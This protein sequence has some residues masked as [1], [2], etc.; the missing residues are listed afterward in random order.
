[1]RRHAKFTNHVTQ[2]IQIQPN[3]VP[4]GANTNFINNSMSQDLINEYNYRQNN[5][6]NNNDYIYEQLKVPLIVSILFFIFNLNTINDNLNAVFPSL[7]KSD[8]TL[9]NSGFALKSLLFGVAYYSLNNLLL[10]FSKM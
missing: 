8:S 3:Y 5:I 7:F 9:K 4:N 10:Y 2:D 6:L 1:M